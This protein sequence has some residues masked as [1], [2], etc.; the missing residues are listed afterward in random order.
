[1]EKADANQC[2]FGFAI[3]VKGGTHDAKMPTR[4]ATNSCCIGRELNR[5]CSGG[6]AHLALCTTVCSGLQEQVRFDMTG[7]CSSVSL[8]TF[9]LDNAIQKI[10][11]VRRWFDQQ[12]KEGG[13]AIGNCNE[14]VKDP[15]RSAGL[16]RHRC[17]RCRAEPSDGPRCQTR[18]HG[19]S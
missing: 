6:H 3:E 1:M 4:F 14:F 11:P 8:T 17:E 16:G 7:M 10:R 18:G 9:D 19:I 5:R 13:R 15:K 12:H 2:E